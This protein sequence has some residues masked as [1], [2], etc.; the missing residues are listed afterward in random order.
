MCAAD[1]AGVGLDA[2]HAVQMRPDQPCCLLGQR[3]AL[4]LARGAA[5][6]HL[7]EQAGALSRIQHRARCLRC[8]VRLRAL[9]EIL[10]KSGGRRVEMSLI[11]AAALAVAVADD[12]HAA[13]FAIHERQAVDDE[14]GEP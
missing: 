5:L 2:R 12:G 4:R 8:P 1:A 13:Q 10:D 9:L 7:V 11:G 3:H 6:G 14:A